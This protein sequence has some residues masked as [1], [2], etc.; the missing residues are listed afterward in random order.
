MSNKFHVSQQ[1]MAL[2]D[3]MNDEMAAWALLEWCCE[4]EEKNGRAA[5]LRDFVDLKPPLV[6]RGI[7]EEQQGDM[8]IVA[9]GEGG[10]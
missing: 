3:G 10:A 9:D 7:Y 8:T 4:F 6:Y 5:T 1:L 2:A